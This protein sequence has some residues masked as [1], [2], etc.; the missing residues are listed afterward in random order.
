MMKNRVTPKSLLPLL[1]LALTAIAGPSLA[2]GAPSV[3]CDAGESLQAKVDA[4]KPGFTIHVTGTCNERITIVTDNITL[5][6]GGTAVIDGNTPAPVPGTGSLFSVRAANV[7]VKGFTIRDGAENGLAIGRSGSAIIENNV[8]QGHDRSGV[9]INN[10]AYAR[11]GEGDGNAPHATPG[12][13]GNTISG[14][15]NNGV[16]I[17]SNGAADIF[18]NVITQNTGSGINLNV[19]ATAD[20]D[21]N[22]ITANSNAGV[23]LRNGASARLDATRLHGS[24]GDRNLIEGNLRAVDCRTNSSLAGRG[25]DVGTGNTL[26]DRNEDDTCAERVSGFNFP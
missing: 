17:N 6:G 7:V 1:A 24:A 16:S 19:G 12:N 3:D 5:D 8:I 25:P 15:G 10:G 21:G 13:R 20:I 4:A 11:L 2:A 23:R 18:H 22:E 9:L 14:N 26:P